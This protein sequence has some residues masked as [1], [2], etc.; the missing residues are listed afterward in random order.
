MIKT[1]IGIFTISPI[2]MLALIVLG[3]FNKELIYHFVIMCIIVLIYYNA[4]FK[5]HEFSKEERIKWSFYLF[6]FNIFACV[7]YYFKFILK[8]D[9]N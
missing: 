2:V 3:V 5:R 9:K 7:M 8:K 4:V 6:Y 1:A